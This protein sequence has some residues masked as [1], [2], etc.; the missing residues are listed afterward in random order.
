M[1]VIQILG[2]SYC[3]STALGFSLNTID[4]AL[5]ASE[6]V[7]ATQKFRSRKP[8]GWLPVCDLCGSDCEFWTKE[9]M[10][11]IN[12][13]DG[14]QEVYEKFRE[15]HPGV[16]H[17]ID[18]SKS[19][20]NFRGTFPYKKII[21]MKHPLKMVAS[22][23]YNDRK[24]HG[25]YEDSYDGFRKVFLKDEHISAVSEYLAWLKKRY[26]D[27]LTK[28]PDAF[29]FKADESHLG[30]FRDFGK[31]EEYL[32]LEAGSIKPKTFSQYPCHSLGGNRAPVWL[33]KKKAGVKLKR[34][35]RLD[36]YDQ[37]SSYGDWK[38]DDKWK[39]LLSSGFVEKV[40]LLDEYKE[41]CRYL[42]YEAYLE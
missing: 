20:D 34:N 15:K 18:A 16:K 28:N 3:G 39:F 9:F 12:D 17:F 36:F 19:M 8:D 23:F 10:L 1:K 7:R 42:G 25:I 11:S 35:H 5:F 6:V 4:G 27:F 22:K 38:I 24:K 40:F 14:L 32:E 41:I 29:I 31:L 2:P 30:G 21:S 37:A 13:S 33:G 26:E